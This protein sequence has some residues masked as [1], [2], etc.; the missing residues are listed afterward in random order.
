[1]STDF[2]GQKK[3]QEDKM[4]IRPMN[5]RVLVKRVEQEQ[6]TDTCGNLLAAGV[7]E[8]T[9]VV[10]FGFQNAASVYGLML[11][12]E[13]MI[14]EKPEK[15]KSRLCL[16]AVWEKTC[17]E[18]LPDK[19]IPG[20]SKQPPQFG[21]LFG[22]YLVIGRHSLY[23]AFEPFL[24]DIIVLCRK[25]TIIQKSGLFN[26]FLHHFNVL[27]AF[28][29]CFSQSRK[30]SHNLFQPACTCIIYKKLACSNS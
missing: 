14:S 24:F 18:H 5:D 4:R 26:L 21:C 27:S 1:M 11:T 8:T 20:R 25:F 3:Q 9:K 28:F 29:G 10:R 30:L 13:A 16:P 7:I 15:K 23:G 2:E 12:T 22:S 19:A 17:T 6:Q